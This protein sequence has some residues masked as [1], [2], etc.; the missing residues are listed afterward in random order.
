VPPGSLAGITVMVTDNGG[1]DEA[2]FI[3]IAG[4]IQP[5]QL[6][7]IA[8]AIGMDGMFNRVPGAT[9]PSAPS[10]PSAPNTPDK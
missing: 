5:A 4:T 6:G 2:V 1:G 7:R 9:A 3:N 10:A 8:G